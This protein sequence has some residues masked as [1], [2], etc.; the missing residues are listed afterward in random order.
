MA[1]HEIVANRNAELLVESE[2]RG[3]LR[4]M[5][6]L[7]V[8]GFLL[9]RKASSGYLRGVPDQGELRNWME[10]TA[11]LDGRPAPRLPKDPARLSGFATVL[12]SAIYGDGR[13][14]LLLTTADVDYLLAGLN[15]G[16]VTADVRANLALL[17]RD[18]LIE[19][20]AGSESR[21]SISRAFVIETL[22]RAVTE[23]LPVVQ[24][25]NPAALV[26]T[27]KTDTA[28]PAENGRLF[29][30]PQI[31][32]RPPVKSTS[33]TPTASHKPA[34]A[35]ALSRKSTQTI[36]TTPKVASAQPGREMTAKEIITR[37]ALNTSNEKRDSGI[38][39][40][41]EA[42]LFRRFGDMSYPV[43]HLTLVGG[44]NVAFHLSSTG[45]VD[46]LEASPSE[47]G[48]SSDRFSSVAQWQQRITAEEMQR[49]LARANVNVGTIENIVPVEFTDSNRVIE[50]EVSGYDGTARLHSP[51]L[52]SILGLKENMFVVDREM[53]ARGR[54]AA[55]IF[56]GRGWGHGVGMCQV[57]AY[58]LARDVYSYTQILEMYY[59]GVTVQKIY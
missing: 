30:T 29:L 58:G 6:L 55:F 41:P 46:F 14:N 26:S 15:I 12:A 9:P 5:A 39:V 49:R 27:L 53:D 13:A 47:R 44:E 36:K 28:R 37:P 34:N 57:G 11:E 43:T 56:T 10:R 48:A 52:R 31:A 32:V 16:P 21:G 20:P 24:K 54:V 7:Q 19:L 2:A 4:D 45:R 22:A 18:H 3:S 40:E 38:E 42:W 33:T 51:Q 35:N 1:S 8:L 25:S 50:I 23:R 59:S 17:L